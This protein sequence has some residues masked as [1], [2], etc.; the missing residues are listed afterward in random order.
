MVVPIISRS[1][2]ER[3]LET[4]PSRSVFLSCSLKPENFRQSCDDMAKKNASGN[5]VV[6]Y[7]KISQIDDGFVDLQF[8]KPQVKIPWKAITLAVF[9]FVV[10]IVLI[11]IGSLLLT[12]YID[13]KHT[14]S[15]WILIVLG[16]LMF[17]PG[18]YHVGIVYYAYCSYPGYSYDDIPDF[19]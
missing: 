6:R 17:I 13:A 1:E 11:I 10:G 12:G 16:S 19:N 8:E 18:G 7:H 15:T 3:T 9:L 5:S 4:S 14:E 2:K